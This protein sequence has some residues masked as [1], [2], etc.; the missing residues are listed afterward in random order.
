MVATIHC[1]LPPSRMKGL[2]KMPGVTQRVT[3]LS[4]VFADLEISLRCYER[5]TLCCA[6]LESCRSVP[7]LGGHSLLRAAC[8]CPG[9]PDSPVVSS[10]ELTSLLRQM[11]TRSKLISLLLSAQICCLLLALGMPVKGIRHGKS[12]CSIEEGWA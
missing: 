3:R 11:L 4:A 1:A 2:I 6:V 9:F 12:L 5:S 8:V 10:K 7:G